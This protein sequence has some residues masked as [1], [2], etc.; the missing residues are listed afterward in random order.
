MKKLLLMSVIL[1]PCA[2]STTDYLLLMNQV[3]NLSS[4][5]SVGLGFSLTSSMYYGYK[6]VNELNE[7]NRV[8]E[9]NHHL[10]HFRND[11]TQYF[12]LQSNGGFLYDRNKISSI[13][14]AYEKYL[15][16]DQLKLS[17]QAK[18]GFV[19][20]SFFYN[21]KQNFMKNDQ[22][23]LTQE[24]VDVLNNMHLSTS[25]N[26][27]ITIYNKKPLL[28]SFASTV[29]FSLLFLNKHSLHF[30]YFFNK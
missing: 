17:Q 10:A 16:I 21:N 9:A 28:Y 22:I 7:V 20:L 13:L 3:I 11:L 4:A 5:V 2:S 8:K 26:I 14:T 18:D 30:N 29:F 12:T 15:S 1:F 24:A 25:N 27:D 19:V 23:Y 6:Y